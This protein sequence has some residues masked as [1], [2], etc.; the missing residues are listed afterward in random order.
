MLAVRETGNSKTHH[1]VENE[2]IA[3]LREMLPAQAVATPVIV[4]VSGGLDSVCLAHI[5]A[6]I[7]HSLSLAPV[8]VHVNHQLRNA[9]STRD[10][11]FVRALG[12]RLA[13]PT[14]VL[15]VHVDTAVASIEATARTARYAALATAAAVAGAQHIITAHHADDQAETVL[16]RIIRGTGISGLAAMRAIAPVVGHPTLRLLRPMLRIMRAELQDYAGT[17]GLVHVVDSSNASTDMLRNRV[18][19]ELLPLLGGYNAGI[20]KT[21]IHLADSAADDAELIAAA[22]TAAWNSICVP[23]AA[24]PTLRRTDWR[25]LTPGLQRAVL[26]EGCVRVQGHALH[27]RFDA[28]EEARHV[29]RS[30]TR[31]ARIGLH[32]R[33]HIALTQYDVRFVLT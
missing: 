9:E 21:L 10:A 22:Q 14:R 33:L 30:D 19:H 1:R 18:R 13:L 8:L 26:R 27:V 4:A 31:E 2:L 3:Q 16:L 12:V 25:Q 17:I 29:I 24:S 6:D 32:G 15:P 20:R 28:I 5:L 11:E 7:A 23:D